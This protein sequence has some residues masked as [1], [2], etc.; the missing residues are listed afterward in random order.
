[1]NTY[2]NIVLI[3]LLIVVLIVFGVGI[4]RYYAEEKKRQCGYKLYV[5][6]YNKDEV[7]YAQIIGAYSEE[8]SVIVFYESNEF[9]ES[10]VEIVSV[11]QLYP[12]D[13][14]YY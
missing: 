2:L 4:R 10:D 13:L 6:T 14:G 12:A 7:A 1:M 5:I 8:E 11:K 9:S 3:V